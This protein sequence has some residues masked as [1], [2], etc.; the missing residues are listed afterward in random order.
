MLVHYDGSIWR[1]DVVNLK[2]MEKCKELATL[3]FLLTAEFK[4]TALRDVC[5]KRASRWHNRGVR[6][7]ILKDAASVYFLYGRDQARW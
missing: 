2:A 5:I 7:T 3:L 1:A 6:E 4:D